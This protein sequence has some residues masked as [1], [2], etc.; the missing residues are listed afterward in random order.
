M[1]HTAAEVEAKAELADLRS[2]L[3]AAWA[4]LRQAEQQIAD[5]EERH[6]A[7]LDQHEQLIIARRQAWTQVEGLDY[8]L[9]DVHRFLT[10]PPAPEG[11]EIDT[12]V[13]PEYLE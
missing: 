8:D 9:F 5:F 7:V 1:I 4:D 12:T 11:T 6:R 3:D 2:K 10:E 13:R